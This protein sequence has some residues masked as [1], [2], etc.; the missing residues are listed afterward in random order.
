MTN[1]SNQF[2]QICSCTWENGRRHP[3]IDCPVHI[4]NDLDRPIPVDKLPRLEFSPFCG[5]CNSNKIILGLDTS[6]QYY[7]LVSDHKPARL[8]HLEEALSILAIALP[9]PRPWPTE[10]IESK[11]RIY[12]NMAIDRRSSPDESS[13]TP[14]Q[15]HRNAANAFCEERNR[16]REQLQEVDTVLTDIGWHTDRGLLMRVREALKGSPEETPEA[17]TVNDQI[18][19]SFRSHIPLGR[20][21]AVNPPNV[22]VQVPLLWLAIGAA[23]MAGMKYELGKRSAQETSAQRIDYRIPRDF[24]LRGPD[25]DGVTAPGEELLSQ[26]GKGD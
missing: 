21:L 26:N 2:S 17:Q 14:A 9:G 23:E 5:C 1:T 3:G 25:E 22:L 8:A 10:D 11:L 4:S 12:R 15:Y 7:P 19:E 6:V 13:E 18:L 20:P 16:L 24:G